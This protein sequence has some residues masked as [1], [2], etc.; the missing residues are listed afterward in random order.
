MKKIHDFIEKIT[1]NKLSI[2]YIPEF[3]NRIDLF[4][5]FK[6]FSEDRIKE[7][8]NKKIKEILNEY[9]I[10]NEMKKIILEKLLN[11]NSIFSWNQDFRELERK[12]RT[13]IDELIIKTLDEY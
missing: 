6:K 2:E 4:I 1:R 10:D 9:S 8:I 5:Y 3:I 13:I 7:I 11:N 12:L